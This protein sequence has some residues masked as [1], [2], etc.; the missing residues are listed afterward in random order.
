[1]NPK[2]SVFPISKESAIYILN[3]F[4][5]LL[6]D[7]ERLAKRHAWATQK[8]NAQ[9]L[10]KGEKPGFKK[11]NWLSEDPKVLNLL[12]QGYENFMLDAATRI[13]EDHADKVFLNTCPKCGRLA[14]TPQARQCRYCGYT[15][16]DLTVAKFKMKKA[17]QKNRLAFFLLG[18]ISQGK[19]SIGNYID[20]TMLG[21]NAKPK[22]Y[23][24]E[25]G[26]RKNNENWEDIALGTDDLTLE[27]QEYLKN[28]SKFV[29]PFDIIREA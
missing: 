4:P 25:H 9:S 14:R 26:L 15:W 1:M 21:L 28:L 29:E 10:A 11:S 13:L 22:I 17:V 20:L 24:I 6:N 19:V 5:N 23:H 2:I 16:H 12:A 8:L 27:Q 7:K 18:Q 3:Y